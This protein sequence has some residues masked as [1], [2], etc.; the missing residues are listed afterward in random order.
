MCVAFAS[1][2]LRASARSIEA[3]AAVEHVSKTVL[4]RIENVAHNNSRTNDPSIC[5]LFCL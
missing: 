2:W 4:K 1:R 5:K 3:A